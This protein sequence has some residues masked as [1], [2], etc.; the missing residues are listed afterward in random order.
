MKKLFLLIV[1]TVTALVV[2]TGCGNPVPTPPGQQPG[3]SNGAS[4][5]PADAASVATERGLSQDDIYA[6]LKTFTPSGQ[7]DPYIMFASGGQGGQVL[8][9]GVPSMRILKL[10]SVFTPEPWQGYGFGGSGDT[11]L[12]QG[13]VNDKPVL[14]GDT[15][16]PGLSETNGEYDGQFLFINDKANAR[17]AVIDLRDFAT[18]QIVKN[19]LSLTDHGGSF[20]TPNT[21][22]IIEGPQYAAPFGWEYADITTDYNEKYRGV[23]T[24]WKFDRT[25]GRIDVAQ[26]FALELP[27]YWQDLCDAGKKG[28][29]GWLFCNSINTELAIGGIENGNPPFEAG[30]SKNDTDYLHIINWKKAE[31]LFKAGKTEKVKD[32][33]LIRLD[34]A[35]KEGVVFF[36][37]EP[38]SPH[39]ADVTPG[40]EYVVVGGKLDPHVTIYS[41]DK[42]QKAI[43]ALNDSSPKDAYGIPVLP[44]DATMEAQVELGLGPL[45]TVYDDKGY[46]YTS[47]FLDSVVARWTLGGPYQ[48]LHAEE[49]WTLVQKLPVQYNIGHI[50]A[51]EGD[52]ASPDGNFV[53]ALNKWSIDRFANVGPLLPQNFQLVDTSRPG[54]QMKVLYDMPIGMA[55]PHYAQIIKADKLKPWEVYPPG[56]NAETMQPDPNAISA[57]DQAKIVRNGNKVEIWTAVIRSHFTPEHVKLKK[58]D[59][60]TWHFSNLEQTRDATHGFALPGY[61]VNL[62]LEPGKTET[63]EFVADKDG[64][65]AFYCTEFCSALHLEMAGYMMVEP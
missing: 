53:V 14:W 62:S 9:V 7:L 41:F 1:L 11:I 43:A 52:T 26:S 10:I 23:M 63:L 15:H 21:D 64:T 13:K 39:G 29:D 58:G 42:I 3:G 8:V 38:K 47:L 49:P 65:F 55:E 59:Q 17:V 50:A 36:T 20:V 2:V 5:L 45:H 28:S 46:A 60:V 18:K 57:P 22:Y 19:P 56:T 44:L 61:N 54:D 6:A 34:T 25:Q 27:P 30:T 51:A 37:P 32:M 33:A 35:I 31:E 4:G 40:G 24:L 16:H 48:S 12:A